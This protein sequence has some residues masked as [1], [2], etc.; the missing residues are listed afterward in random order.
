MLKDQEVR[1]LVKYRERHF[2]DDKNDVYNHWAS[3]L[4]RVLNPLEVK[5]ALFILDQDLK[6]VNS[7]VWDLI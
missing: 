4:S 3:T 2:K 7:E 1:A 5:E 6:H